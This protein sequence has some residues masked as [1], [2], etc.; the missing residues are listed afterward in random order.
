MSIGPSAAEW[1]VPVP[2]KETVVLPCPPL[3]AAADAAGAAPCENEAPAVDP[4]PAATSGP[5]F[6]DDW[7][8]RTGVEILADASLFNFSASALA[9]IFCLFTGHN[10]EWISFI[11]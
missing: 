8:D 9:S 11:L 2:V 5:A 6:E 3:A 10:C 4:I 1:F 7:V